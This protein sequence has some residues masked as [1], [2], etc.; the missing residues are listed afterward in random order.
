MNSQE[1]FAQSSFY[2]KSPNESWVIPPDGAC[3]GC[4]D[5]SPDHIK[6]GI[7][8]AFI[9]KDFEDLTESDA[10][11]FLVINAIFCGV[12]ES[13]ADISDITRHLGM[14]YKYRR[15]FEMIEKMGTGAPTSA[16]LEEM[17]EL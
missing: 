17:F 9:A 5:I 10:A 15:H 12:S 16:D 14:P 3:L 4:L 2:L 7:L 13:S 11:D 6:M 8:Q 1:T